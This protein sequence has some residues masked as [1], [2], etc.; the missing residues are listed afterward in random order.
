[1]GY[2]IKIMIV[3]RSILIERWTRL[4][5]GSEF[6]F[7]NSIAAISW[8]LTPCDDDVLTIFSIGKK[9]INSVLVDAKPDLFK[10]QIA[11]DFF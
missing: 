11:Y 7:Y 9:I 4:F 5:T 2:D 1:M 3:N 6:I 10:H 8:E